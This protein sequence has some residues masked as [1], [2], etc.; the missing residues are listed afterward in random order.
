MD[1]NQNQ[2]AN[3][4]IEYLKEIEAD[5][6]TLQYIVDALGMSDQLL[7]QLFLQASDLDINN[8][9]EERDSFHDNRKG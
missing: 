5:G 9:I 1:S 4:I 6:E 3:H 7:R 2:S 8:L